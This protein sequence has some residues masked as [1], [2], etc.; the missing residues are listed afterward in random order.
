M[1]RVPSWEEEAA[2]RCALGCGHS[3][4]L[5]GPTAL[6]LQLLQ[7]SSLS[8]TSFSSHLPQVDSRSG[9]SPHSLGAVPDEGPSPAQAAPSSEGGRGRSMSPW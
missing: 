1:A 4:A 7:L 5:V 6:P 9:L 2:G 8:L 3:P